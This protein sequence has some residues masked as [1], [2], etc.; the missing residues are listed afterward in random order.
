MRKGRF[1]CP[2]LPE[3]TLERMGSTLSSGNASPSVVAADAVAADAAS[4]EVDAAAAREE[5][6]EE[7]KVPSLLL[8][9]VLATSPKICSAQALKRA[10][11][12]Q[13]GVDAVYAASALATSFEKA[14]SSSE[15]LRATGVVGLL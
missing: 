1:F 10:A 7:R 4:E 5:D 13:C 11:A 15:A 14:P 3:R 12:A 2:Y 8:P 6:E 9:A